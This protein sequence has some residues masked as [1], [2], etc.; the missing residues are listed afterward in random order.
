MISLREQSDKLGIESADKFEQASK[1]KISKEYK[2]YLSLKNQE[3]KKLN[4]TR[5][6][7][8]VYVKEFLQTKDVD[9]HNKQL[10]EYEKKRED[11]QKEIDE[12][13]NKID[14]FEKDNPAMFKK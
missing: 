10:N 8:T 1:L 3:L 7:M 6:L 14:Q 13:S 9:K 12:L 5:S 11:S 4:D 2:E